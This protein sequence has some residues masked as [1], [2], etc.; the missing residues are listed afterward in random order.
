MFIEDELSLNNAKYILR[1]CSGKY[2][3]LP[4]SELRVLFINDIIVRKPNDSFYTLTEK[5]MRIMMEP[6]RLNK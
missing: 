6:W 5:G 4:H 3:S 1:K 2:D